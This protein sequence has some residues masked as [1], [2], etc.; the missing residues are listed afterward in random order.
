MCTCIHSFNPLR[1]KKQITDI[2]IVTVTGWEYSHTIFSRNSYCWKNS[3]IVW[4]MGSD[5]HFKV[6]C[7]HLCIVSAEERGHQRIRWKCSEIGFPASCMEVLDR[8]LHSSSLL[9]HCFVVFYFTLALAMQTVTNV[10]ITL[11]TFKLYCILLYAVYFY[12]FIAQLW[13][14]AKAS[15]SLGSKLCLV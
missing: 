5:L 14:V 8:V 6:C 12:V 3:I 10:S 4:K 13:P 15:K 7:T 1:T 9:V 2:T 11:F